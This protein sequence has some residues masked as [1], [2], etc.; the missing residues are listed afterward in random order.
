VEEK[1][2]TRR[3]LLKMSALTAMGFAGMNLLRCSNDDTG[4]DVSFNFHPDTY[5]DPVRDALPTEELIKKTTGFRGKRP[6]I[7]IILTDDM[8][9]GDLGCYG[10]RSI[11][12]PNIDRMAQ[13]GMRFTDFHSCNALCS[14]SRAG[15][16]TGRYPHRTG[17]TF[18]IW[19]FEDSPMR[20]V[21]RGFAHL[22]ARVGGIDLIEG[23]SISS[24]LPP[25]EIT[26]AEALKIAEYRTA[27]FG[28]WH[29]GDFTKQPQY[30]PRKQGFDHFVGFNASNDDWPVAF[31]RNEEVLV[32]DIGLDQEKYTR[33]FTEEAIDF[34]EKNKGGPFFVYLAHKDPHQPCI[35][36][37]RFWKSSK[38]GPH[39]DTVQEVD[40]SV[41][42][43]LKCLSR[44]GL[45]RN[46]IVLFT[47]DNGPWYD[48]SP[49][50]LRGRKGQ[51]FEGGFRVP[52]IARWPG[53]IPA[54]VC[55]RP[56]MNIDLFPTLLALAGLELPADRII[57][58]K[59]IWGLLSGK[60]KKS[61]HDALFFF[62]LNE[63]EGVR[64]GRWKYFRHINTYT[65]PLPMDKPNTF[66]GKI[67]GGHDY[68]PEGSDESVPT[69]A[70]WPLLYDMKLDPGENYNVIKHHPEI[71]RQMEEIMSRWEREFIKNPRGWIAKRQ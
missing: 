15:L 61:P 52:L 43:I 64:A 3:H 71:G 10:S 30:H 69:L 9:Y 22:M 24:G 33:L 25:S 59:S 6:N 28:K 44:N 36:S 2:V 11:S 18:P 17:V 35:P 58:G 42:E 7:V 32:S 12:T 68:H 57:D 56:S 53:R 55:S 40:W 47:S 45:D 41:G 70:S 31:C 14:P 39:G 60:E 13:E 49:G 1:T 46:T 51:S 26:I 50:I 65:F 27:A 16:L 8:G 63:L 48:G 19:P 67:A 21:I 23:E 20:T 54:G 66:F 5:V 62:H 37:K 38:G 4:N 34:I 29:L